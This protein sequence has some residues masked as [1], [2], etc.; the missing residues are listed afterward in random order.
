[1]VKF[2]FYVTQ[3]EVKIACIFDCNGINK[4]KPLINDTH[5]FTVSRVYRNLNVKKKLY[6]LQDINFL[7]HSQC[8]VFRNLEL[9]RIV[10]T[11]IAMSHNTS[12]HMHSGRCYSQLAQHLYMYACETFLLLSYM[13]SNNFPGFLKLPTTQGNRMHCCPAKQTITCSLSMGVAKIFHIGGSVPNVMVNM[14][15][16]SGI[17][18]MPPQENFEGLTF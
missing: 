9:L 6:P 7:L 11:S 12:H 16:D 10:A 3:L 1:M 2:E 14:Q 18:S 5:K 13:L 15:D 8:S 4:T 17:W